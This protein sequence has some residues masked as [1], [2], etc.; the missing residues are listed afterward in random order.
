MMA[1][2]IHTTINQMPSL[3]GLG[4]SL[5]LK[6]MTFKQLGDHLAETMLFTDYEVWSIVRTCDTATIRNAIKAC[7]VLGIVLTDENIDIIKS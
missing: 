2:G 1:V 6:T 4:T 5:E 3:S 7:D